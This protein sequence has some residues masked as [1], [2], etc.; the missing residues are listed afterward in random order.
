[1]SPFRFSMATS[2]TSVYSSRRQDLDDPRGQIHTSRRQSSPGLRGI[3]I[4][5][6]T[7]VVERKLSQ[8]T[9]VSKRGVIQIHM[10]LRV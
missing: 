8:H 5:N 10:D 7:N 4:L 6:P 3:E 1:M 9:H 2:T